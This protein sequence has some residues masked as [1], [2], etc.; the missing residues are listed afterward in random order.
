MSRLFRKKSFVS[1]VLVALFAI[2][3][4]SQPCKRAPL[5]PFTDVDSSAWYCTPVYE[6]VS[7]DVIEGFANGEFRPGSETTRAEFLKIALV[8]IYGLTSQAAH[9]AP[10]EDV[11]VDHWASGFVD[12][13]KRNGIVEGQG[14]C[15]FTC[16]RPDVPI[17]R[18]EAAKIL[19][20]TLQC[21]LDER[22]VF[23]AYS[24]FS[25]V[26]TAAWY[27]PYVE[28]L[29]GAEIVD[30]HPDGT[31]RPG[32]LISRAESAKLVFRAWQEAGGFSSPF[33]ERPIDT[34]QV[35]VVDTN[36]RVNRAV[37]ADPRSDPANK[38]V[39]WHRSPGENVIS[40]AVE[41]PSYNA[42]QYAQNPSQLSVRVFGP[43]GDLLG[44]QELE[45]TP[46]AREFINVQV[47]SFDFSRDFSLSFGLVDTNGNFTEIN[48]FDIFGLTLSEY[49]WAQDAL[50][51]DLV[52]LS[53]LADEWVRRFKT[54]EWTDEELRPSEE[55]R[56][57]ISGHRFTHRIGA[58]MIACPSRM[59][60]DGLVLDESLATIPL[61][62]YS[63][64]SEGSNFAI[65][66]NNLAISL[67]GYFTNL[68]FSEVEI[69]FE[70]GREISE[71]IR[72]AR[73]VLYNS[74]NPDC[75]PTMQ[76]CEFLISYPDFGNE[77]VGNVALNPVD[78]DF[79][80]RSRSTV[81][82]DVERVSADVLRLE[83]QT[84]SGKLRIHD[85]FD[86]DYHANVMG[87]HPFFPYVVIQAAYGN[88]GNGIG[89]V[90]LNRL[91][92]DGDLPWPSV[93]PSSIDKER[94]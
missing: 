6:L 49:G 47:A 33:E 52:L 40:I 24:G 90:T 78:V 56:V 53:G 54:G 51:L 20:L 19:A 62:S 80:I 10:F 45:A 61:Y 79:D 63:P 43:D 27:A 55:G 94:E 67:L 59:T 64:G 57:A 8:A 89:Q 1:F 69:A 85:I 35:D 48:S 65:D 88:Q 60:G 15:G 58:D 32:D 17:T 46:G 50:N 36:R 12:F 9:E 68:D 25:D 75:M 66:D 16:F 44:S 2:P 4:F 29:Y 28:L 42:L 87:I 38:L 11:T 71:D 93:L 84:L 83:F 82:I 5:D 7:R 13:A 81:E 26:P 77:G 3:V 34:I 37:P 21:H 73:F 14:D 30:G 31:F 18:A 72:R 76:G 39:L 22:I 70:E 86:Y 92:L 91:E 23:R 74:A 41:V